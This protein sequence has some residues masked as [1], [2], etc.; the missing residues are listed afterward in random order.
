MYRVIYITQGGI[1]TSTTVS[2]CSSRDEA[3]A[4]ARSRTQ[5]WGALVSVTEM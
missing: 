1:Q 4:M 2:G 3:V 5:N